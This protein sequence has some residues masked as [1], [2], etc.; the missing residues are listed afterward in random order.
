MINL[1][2]WVQLVSIISP[3][4]PQWK[5]HTIAIYLRCIWP[6]SSGKR[7]HAFQLLLLMDPAWCDFSKIKMIESDS[8]DGILGQRCLSFNFMQSN[9]S[10]RWVV[11]RTRFSA[12]IGAPERSWS[13]KSSMSC[14]K[15][16]THFQKVMFE[17]ASS[18]H[19]KIKSSWISLND[20]PVYSKPKCTLQNKILALFFVKSK[21][22]KMLITCPCKFQN[23]EWCTYFVHN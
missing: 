10:P 23:R 14:L 18:G 12:V 17:W 15:Q 5:C 7:S 2:A 13:F 1:I 19:S 9:L 22:A 20:C 3:T 6:N 4:C 8:L 21:F 11:L 16:S